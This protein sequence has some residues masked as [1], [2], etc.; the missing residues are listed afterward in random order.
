MERLRGR[1]IESLR[2]FLNDASASARVKRAALISLGRLEDKTSIP[3][4]E[5]MLR[6]SNLYV[7]SSAVLS[8]GL[9]QNSSARYTLLN[10]AK[11]TD[12]AGKVMDNAKTPADIRAFA[13]AALALSPSDRGGSAAPLFREIALDESC[14]DSVRAMALEGLGLLGGDTAARFLAEF[15][16]QKKVD[17]R[18]RSAALTALG[19]TGDPAALPCLLE[20]LKSRHVFLQQSA[21]LA[22]GQAAPRGD[23][24]AV[25][26]LFTA[27][28]KTSNRSLKG[29][30]LASMG[31]IGG[32]EA[33]E[34]LRLVF[35]RGTSAD[36]P[37]ACLGLGLAL[38]AAP[39]QSATPDENRADELLA[40]LRTNRN[41]STQGAAAVAL[42]L[43][44]CREASGD[45]VELLENGDDPYLRG[46]CA[47]ALGMIG[48]KS[49]VPV[50]RGALHELNLP[51]ITTQA[52]LALGLLNDSGSAADLLEV[53]FETRSDATKSMIARSLVFI[54]DSES[55]KELLE[56]ISSK[57]S[58][59]ITYM[60]T[61]ELIASLVS[62]QKAPFL[63]RMAAGSNFT[64][65]Y[66]I[67][68]YLLEFGV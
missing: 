7:R 20:N 43:A 34:K 46:Y 48:E 16:A 25:R 47:L 66:P 67:V 55:A 15:C 29:F 23:V 52:A 50:L 65:E 61:M 42:G 35:K 6:D 38:S 8:L 54:G 4:I 33:I 18:L 24:N 28:S 31:Q 41:R 1:S 37:W 63:D 59:E 9:S 53:F 26:Q 64:C 12:H 49:A 3:R 30:A 56:F 5:G 14:D 21:A 36:L 19:K 22:L 68:P 32:A 58:S 27:F 62:G 10:L 57:W 17:T 13:V 11:D 40:V 45:L 51:P 39:A 2:L 44:G 60:Y